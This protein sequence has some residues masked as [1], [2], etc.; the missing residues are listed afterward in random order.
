MLAILKLNGNINVYFQRGTYVV[1]FGEGRKSFPSTIDGVANCLLNRYIEKKMRG[2]V[3][4]N[5]SVTE[6]LETMKSIRKEILEGIAPSI[7]LNRALAEECDRLKRDND[8]YK[9]A[10]TRL[11]NQVDLLERSKNN[12]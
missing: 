2:C 9:K 5:K 8:A 12:E 1:D 4:D 10:N 7:E 6:L 11:K 3:R